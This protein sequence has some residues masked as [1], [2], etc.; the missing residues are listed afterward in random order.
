MEE[1]KLK[2]IDLSTLQKL[3]SQET[4]STIYTDGSICYKFWFFDIKGC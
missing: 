1:I 4:Q 2:E 3:Q